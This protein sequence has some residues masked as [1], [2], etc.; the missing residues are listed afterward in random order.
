M[1][2]KIKFQLH[3]FYNTLMSHKFYPKIKSVQPKNDYKLTVTFD[4]NVVKEYDCKPILQKP[5]F[6]LLREPAF[7]KSVNV[8]VGGYGIIWN[9]QLDLSEYEL[10]IHG[11]TIED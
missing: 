9:D 4:N 6:H 2:K 7:F 3:Q 11:V 10:W 5:F 1:S 8:D